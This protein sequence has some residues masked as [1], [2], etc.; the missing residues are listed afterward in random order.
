MDK[1]IDFRKQSDGKA[2][3]TIVGII[4]GLQGKKAYANGKPV[5]AFWQLRTFL[6]K[7]DRL[8]LNVLYDYICTLE[9]SQDSLGQL[10]EKAEQYRQDQQYSK[11]EGKVYEDITIGEV[12]NL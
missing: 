10:F 6:K 11:G 3:N 2:L 5:Q 9:T 1:Q 4:L 8:R 7:Q 12:L